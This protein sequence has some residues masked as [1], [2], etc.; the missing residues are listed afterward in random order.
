MNEYMI[1]VLESRPE[2]INEPLSVQ[3]AT[4]ISTSRDLVELQRL[5]INY[6][7]NML[8]EDHV[9]LDIYPTDDTQ[10]VAGVLK[11]RPMGLFHIGMRLGAYEEKKYIKGLG[12]TMRDILL[13]K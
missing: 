7:E 10:L 13:D 3:A 1:N 12:K 9:Q 6:N 4:V 8:E 2:F 11:G 5:V